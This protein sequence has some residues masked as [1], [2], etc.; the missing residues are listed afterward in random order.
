MV[1]DYVT[2]SKAVERIQPEYL[3]RWKGYDENHDQWVEKNNKR[4]YC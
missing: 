3:V 2:G 4:L 1:R